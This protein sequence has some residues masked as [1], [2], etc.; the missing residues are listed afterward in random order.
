M[1]RVRLVVTETFPLRQPVLV[2]YWLTEAEGRGFLVVTETPNPPPNLY[3]LYD[4]LRLVVTHGK[5]FLPMIYKV[6][7][8]GHF[9]LAVC[10]VHDPLLATA[11]DGLLTCTRKPFHHQVYTLQGERVVSLPSDPGICRTCRSL[12]LI[13]GF[14]FHSKFVKE[15]ISFELPSASSTHG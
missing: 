11:L 8:R 5:P 12:R 6:L 4:R 13:E 14:N 2:D 3:F 7:S 10:L 9:D 1:R 15:V